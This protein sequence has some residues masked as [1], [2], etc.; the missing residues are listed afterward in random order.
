[1]WASRGPSAEAQHPIS[2]YRARHRVHGSRGCVRHH[3][4]G[5]SHV[6]SAGCRTQTVEAATPLRHLRLPGELQ[7]F[8]R[9]SQLTR[10]HQSGPTGGLTRYSAVAEPR[11]AAGLRQPEDCNQSSV[12]AVQEFTDSQTN[13]MYRAVQ[14]FLDSKGNQ[15]AHDLD[16]SLVHGGKQTYSLSDHAGCR[17][18]YKG[19]SSAASSICNV[20]LAVG[21]GQACPLPHDSK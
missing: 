8:A 21:S 3:R 6:L 1:M 18:V 10:V 20:L 4:Q 19:G 12:P 9:T 15:G 11:V 2:R 17:D 13:Q 16:V 5:V 14:I 7:S